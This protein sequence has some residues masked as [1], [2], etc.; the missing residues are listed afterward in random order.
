ME[1]RNV[2]T[3]ERRRLDFGEGKGVRY[4]KPMLQRFMLDT[5]ET[6]GWIVSKIFRTAFISGFLFFSPDRSDFFLLLFLGRFCLV[7]HF[8]TPV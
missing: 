4:C 5:C 6:N 3:E 8:V 2:A 1:I 7:L